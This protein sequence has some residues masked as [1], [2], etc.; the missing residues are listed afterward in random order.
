MIGKASEP[1]RAGTGAPRAVAQKGVFTMKS[2]KLH[3]WESALLVAFAV[4]LL[5]GCCASAGRAAL[6]DRVLRLHVVANSDSA[7]DQAVKLKVR[8]AVLAQ[9]QPAL[10]GISDS[11]QAEVVLRPMLKELEQTAGAVLESEGYAPTVSVE[12]SDQWFPTKQYEHFALP[13]GEYRALRVVIG[14][15]EGQNWW[16]V[17][18]PPLCLAAVSEEVTAAAAMAGLSEEQVALITG[19]DGGYVL[20]FKVIEWWEELVKWIKLRS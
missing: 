11:G 12:I 13:A 4:F 10:E 19:Q 17:V 16:C 7:E 15:G 1:L 18:F 2:Q 8:D 20:K 9:A 6:A 5:V 3:L 14:E